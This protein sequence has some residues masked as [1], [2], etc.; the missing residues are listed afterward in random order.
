[1]L[2]KEG[3]KTEQYEKL[4]EIN[5]EIKYLAEKYMA[6]RRTETHFVGFE[7]SEFASPK[8]SVESLSTGAIYGLRA[9]NGAPLTVGEMTS[10][11]GD[12]RRAVMICPCDDPYDTNEKEFDIIFS[13]DSG[14]TVFAYGGKGKLTITA[15][16][17]G[18]YSVTAGSNKG[19]FI[20]I[21]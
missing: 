6:Y 11:N 12:T 7:N 9:S 10:R 8:K 14:K 15:L 17:S 20:E 4:K 5:A 2:D 3:N 19:V 16:D 1:M 21:R 13:V 18:E